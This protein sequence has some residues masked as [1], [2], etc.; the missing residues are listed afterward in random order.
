M[1]HLL[2]DASPGWA[3]VCALAA[4]VYASLLYYRHRSTWSR[5][6]NQLLFAI[7]FII[8]FVL[9]L[10]LLGFM[11]R[12]TEN[13]YEKPVFAILLDNS[14]SLRYAMDSLERKDLTERTAVLQEKLADLN[15]DT[16]LLGLRGNE[17][18]EVQ[19]HEQGTNLSNA[20]RLTADRFEGR[21]LEGV[22]L[23]SDGIYTSG[24]SPADIDFPAPVF[25][26]G[27]GD[28]I[29]R[30]D[31]AVHDVL[32]NKL[33]YQGARFPVRAEIS[34][35]GFTGE[36]MRITLSY[37][38]RVV[39]EQQKV[40]PPSG[41]VQV[42]FLTEAQEEGIHRWDVAVEVKPGEVNR[43]NNR[44]SFFI[45][46][47]KGKRR[48]LLLA[49]TP[50]PDIRTLRMILEKNSNYEVVLH[51]PGIQEA[52]GKNLVSENLDL[53]IF[54]QLPDI[55]GRLREQYTQLVKT[56]VPRFYI[57]GSTTD[58]ALTM[59]P[60]FPVGFETMPRQFDEVTPAL[61]PQ[62]SQF[63]LPAEATAI[64]SAMPPMA[65]RFGK[66]RIAPQVTTILYQQVGSV[67]TDR[68]LL[69]FF[70]EETRKSGI[71]MGEGLYRWRMHEFSRTGRTEVTDEL[72]LK[73]IQ[74]L[75]TPDDKR[76]FR[77]FTM[78]PEFSEDEPV[79]FESQVY[80]EI[81]EPV[82]GNTIELEITDEHNKRS[83]FSYII[84]PSS[85]R[86]AVQGLKEGA[87][88]Y[89]ATADVGG[90]RETVRGQFV[91]TGKQ[92]ELQNLTADHNLLR[93]IAQNTGGMF[94]TLNQ[95]ETLEKTLTGIEARYVVRSEEHY[96]A[97]LNIPWL[98]ILL[99]ILAGL[100]W[101]V[102][103]FY[104]GY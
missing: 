101:L 92:V 24:I 67:V 11:L 19:F 42:E 57:T 81:Y 17:L 97:A 96:T 16:P 60:S 10:L 47:V 14:A 82:Y 33:T 55:R 76:R 75:A 9:A 89:T 65:V 35:R 95:W 99:I 26:V 94:F 6:I 44:T 80:N 4:L 88:R 13:Q 100:E 73:F 68:P 102:R 29:Q 84:Q 72:F 12:H 34:A 69:A 52:E 37:K 66:M 22:L 28:T 74:F 32:Y 90:K 31:L 53:I 38:G 43:Q 40:V 70:Y 87:Y 54:Y 56:P 93:S 104:G 49:A 36:S 30:P 77:C 3:F 103:K 58:L 15:F 83:Q 98:L 85:A 25:T 91:V 63:S 79:L 46:V 45:E 5:K 59:Q 86:Y 27:V 64:L 7:R 51:I 8:V 23:I 71:L 21:R 2:S 48:I 18:K 50:H 39:A 20:L 1:T 61:S 62:F 41:F 78:K